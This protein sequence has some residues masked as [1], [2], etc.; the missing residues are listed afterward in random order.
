MLAAR[1][2]PSSINVWLAGARAFYAWAASTRRT[3]TNP[4]ADVKGVKRKGV[5]RMHKRDRLTNAEVRRPWPWI[6][7]PE[8]AP[9]SRCG[10]T[11]ASATWRRTGL[12]CATSAPATA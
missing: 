12:I 8:T 3:H 11:P 2:T 1:H 5:N 4:L 6:S 7:R 9:T 10:S